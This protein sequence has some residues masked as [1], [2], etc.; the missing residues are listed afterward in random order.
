MQLKTNT[1]NIDIHCHSSSKQSMRDPLVNKQLLEGFAFQPESKF[2]RKTQRSLEKISGVLQYTQA[3]FDALFKG[4]IRVACISMTPMEKAFGVM[5]R[6]QVGFFKDVLKTLLTKKKS[7]YLI[8]PKPIS[9]LTGYDESMISYLQDQL[10]DYYEGL[11]MPE[12]YYLMQ[13][14]N[15]TRKVASKQYTIRFP[16]NA[17]ELNNYAKD[18]TNLSIIL[19]IE[20]LHSL[21]RAPENNTI[22]QNQHNALGDALNQIDQ[23]MQERFKIRINEL[24][25]T[26]RVRPLFVSLNH[27]FWN[28]LGGHAR[29]LGK[30]I[31]MLVAQTEGLHSGLTSNG[32]VVIKEL[33]ADKPIYIDIKHMSA[34]CRK[35]YYELLR[36]DTQLK[37]KQ[38]P[39][40]CS[41][42]GIAPIDSLQ[43]LIANS[44]REEDIQDDKD[45]FLYHSN[46]NLCTEELQLILDSKGLIGIQLD[47]K[48]ISGKYA[49]KGLKNKYNNQKGN[50]WLIY[51]KLIWANI[52]QGVRALN[53]KNAWTIFCIGSDY[54]GLINHLDEY[55]S[56]AEM[57]VLRKDMLEFLTKS[58]DDIIEMDFSLT[59]TEMNQL[60]KPFSADEIVEMIF[61]K[62]ARR[63]FDTWFR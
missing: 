52:F 61:E 48:R 8:S 46:I 56:A 24:K 45:N 51:I 2:F 58:N 20:G 9:A 38:V 21:M 33:L 19:T 63:F 4:G 50:K 3:H 30:D 34:L 6:T 36:N 7:E 10:N 40:I 42:T 29:S 39:I 16:R 53:T 55:P 26:W 32:Q 41:H 35:Q 15:V 27:H 12:Y 57:N 23:D 1:M 28:R 5:N 62:N 49:I 13:F 44:N 17:N 31:T 22:Y 18:E 14:E 59:R 60:I 54:D 37:K 43:T 47:E 11:L 25:N